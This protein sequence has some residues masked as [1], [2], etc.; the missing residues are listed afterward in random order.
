MNLEPV[1]RAPGR[2]TAWFVATGRAL[3]IALLVAVG[4]ACGGPAPRDLS[5]LVVVDSVYRDPV[6]E[7]PF[8]GPV[9][10][11]FADAPETLQLE[12]T[13]SAGLWDG[14]LVVYHPNG[15]VRYMGSFVN[16]A[17]CGPW[18]ENADSV[19]TESTYDELLREIESLGIYPPCDGSV[20]GEPE[21]SR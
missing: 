18:T 5:D 20:P 3:A 2:R 16:G 13:L 15:R 9:F 8:T 4:T 12:G 17:R 11:A 1:P 7:A 6:T 21:G 14:E 10:R 19:P